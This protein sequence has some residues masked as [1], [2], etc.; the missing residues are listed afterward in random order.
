WPED[1]RSAIVAQRHAADLLDDAAQYDE[2]E[3]VVDAPGPWRIDEMTRE[4]RIEHLRPRAGGSMKNFSAWKAGRMRQQLKDGDL[5]LRW[6]FKLWDEPPGVVAQP[7]LSGL[8]QLHDGRR[9]RYDLC[10]RGNVEDCV[11]G[12]PGRRWIVCFATAG[13]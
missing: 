4:N 9:R 7:K 6:P 5:A 12:H 13:N 2:A 11:A 8:C 1:P 3:I 10:E